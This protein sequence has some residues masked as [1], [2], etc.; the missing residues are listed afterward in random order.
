LA[1]ASGSPKCGG[2]EHPWRPR[3][4]AARP[5]GVT[6]HH[7]RRCKCLA[8]IPRL[9]RWPRAAS[10]KWTQDQRDP[11][12]NGYAG[13]FDSRLRGSWQPQVLINVQDSL[14][15]PFPFFELPVKDTYRKVVAVG[16]A[17]SSSSPNQGASGPF[18]AAYWRLTS[19]ERSSSATATA[20]A[21]FQ[22]AGPSISSAHSRRPTRRFGRCCQIR[23]LQLECRYP[24]R[25]LSWRYR[26]CRCR[27][28]RFRWP[29]W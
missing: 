22:R 18:R 5:R 7:R 9:P 6:G 3:M 2:G 24:A 8:R 21:R 13:R 17:R 14:G 12:Q 20:N 4:P 19:H 11:A 28:L 29:L 16:A 10:A 1:S 25:R 15:W 27:A 26:P 23:Y